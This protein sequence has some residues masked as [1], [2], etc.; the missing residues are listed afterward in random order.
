MKN[1]IPNGFTELLNSFDPTNLNKLPAAEL[2]KVF[3]LLKDSQQVLSELSQYSNL[4]AHISPIIN[5]YKEW[6]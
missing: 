6:K 5:R 3:S 4:N 1:N 2:I